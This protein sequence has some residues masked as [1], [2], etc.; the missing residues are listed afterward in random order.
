[1]AGPKEMTEGTTFSG[2]ACQCGDEARAEMDGLRALAYERD[3][4]SVHPTHPNDWFVTGALYALAGS[5]WVWIDGVPLDPGG[6][7]AIVLETGDE[8]KDPFRLDIQFDLFEDGLAL[9]LDACFKKWG[10]HRVLR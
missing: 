1:M 8:D 5:Y 6:W 9:A 2:F 7:G 10:T 4:V 3:Q